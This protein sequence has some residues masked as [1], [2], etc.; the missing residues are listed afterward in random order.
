MLYNTSETAFHAD[1]GEQLEVAKT[2]DCLQGV[3]NVI[4]L[5]LIGY[6]LG[7]LRGNAVDFPRHVAKS[8]TVE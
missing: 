5:Q 1:D 4:P 2:V 8:V 6:W 7:V 3:L